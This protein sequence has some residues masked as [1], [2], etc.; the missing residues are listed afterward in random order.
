M[1]FRALNH[2]LGGSKSGKAPKTKIGSDLATFGQNLDAPKFFCLTLTQ[3]NIPTSLYSP[4][5][6]INA[7]SNSKVRSPQSEVHKCVSIM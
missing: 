3:S 1:I 7:K 5:E 6:K 2:I 4:W